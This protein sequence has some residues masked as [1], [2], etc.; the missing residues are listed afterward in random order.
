LFGLCLQLLVLL[1]VSADLDVTVFQE[2]WSIRFWKTV[3]CLFLFFMVP[4]LDYYFVSFNNCHVKK[5]TLV[6]DLGG[7]V[8][9][10]WCLL[11]VTPSLRSRLETRQFL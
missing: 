3:F 4:F 2:Y 1:F 7:L 10:P 9:M 6:S 5:I 11:I 8:K